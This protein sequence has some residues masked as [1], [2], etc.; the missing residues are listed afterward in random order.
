MTDQFT[1]DTST[2]Q[3][4]F[5][6]VVYSKRKGGYL[7]LQRVKGFKPRGT[8]ICIELQRIDLLL[9][10][11][12]RYR[13]AGQIDPMDDQIHICELTVLAELRAQCRNYMFP[14]RQQCQGKPIDE[15]P[16]S[17]IW[18]VMGIKNDAEAWTLYE[19]RYWWKL[20][21]DGS[22]FMLWDTEEAVLER[23]SVS[24][25]AVE[26]HFKT[27]FKGI[28]LEDDGRFA[29]R[30]FSAEMDI[31][32]LDTK[33]TVALNRTELTAEGEKKVRQ[34]QNQYLR[35]FCNIIFHKVENGTVP[36]GKKF[37]YYG[38]WLNCGEKL[39]EKLPEDFVE[40]IQD[41]VWVLKKG[42]D[43][44][45]TPTEFPAKELILQREK[46]AYSDRISD[47]E[48]LRMYSDIEEYTFQSAQPRKIT[49][50]L[51]LTLHFSM[52]WRTTIAFGLW[53]S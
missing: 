30:K 27:A 11:L 39:R 21:H 52:Q 19:N 35:V 23:F 12:W 17:E 37:G 22:E 25:N 49:I 13:M 9:G 43:G 38:Y 29:G 40:K 28:R 10:E 8:T 48:V 44:L 18:P 20:K 47:L 53:I 15:E 36:L 24:K 42:K 6:A 33:K 34:L 3:D 2:G 14:L 26:G 41:R 1:I 50:S 16:E 51:L 46:I 32:G 4:A 5:H 31:Y 45:Y 7:Q